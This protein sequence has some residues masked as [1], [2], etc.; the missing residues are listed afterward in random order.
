M[1]IGSQIR[2]EANGRTSAQCPDL[3]FHVVH[4]VR[5][6]LSRDNAGHALLSP[7]EYIET[8]QLSNFCGEY[9]HVGVDQCKVSN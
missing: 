6:H 8:D 7:T 3:D 2:H 9:A 5:S 4:V 1:T